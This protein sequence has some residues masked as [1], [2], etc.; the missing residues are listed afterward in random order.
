MDTELAK[1][2]KNNRTHARNNADNKKIGV[3]QK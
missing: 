3:V 1:I 2:M